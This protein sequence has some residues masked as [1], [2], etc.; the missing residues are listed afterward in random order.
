MSDAHIFQLLG[1]TFFAIGVGM[2]TRPRFIALIIEDL[3]QSTA[4]MFYG[5]LMSLVIG[6]FL[7]TFH[8]VWRFDRSL[9]ITILGWMALSK[10]LALLILPLPSVRLYKSISAYTGLVQYGV[11]LFG[12]VLLFLGYIA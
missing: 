10:G 9:I 2:F 1:M 6:F 11:V 12:A 8:N 5:G 4:N 3:D 7:V